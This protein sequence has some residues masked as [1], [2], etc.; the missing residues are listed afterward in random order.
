[1]CVATACF[2]PYAIHTNGGHDV[3]IDFEIPADAKAMRERVRQWVHDE[4]MPAEKGCW[5]ASDYKTILNELR[6]KARAQGLWCPFI[7]KEY[8]GMG[9]GPLANALVQM[10]LGESYLGALSMN[11]QGPDDATMLTLL[12]HGT[13]VSE[14]EVPEAAAER[15]EAHLL[16]DDREG[17][18]RRCHRHADARRGKGNDAYLLN[19]E[20]WFS[21]AASVADIALVMAKTD[22]ERAAP[23]AVFDL[24]RRAAE[25]RLQDQAR[26][27]D[28]GAR[29]PA[30]AHPGRRPCRSRDQ[31]PR[32]AGR[33]PAWR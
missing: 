9:L 22:P 16:F 17:G 15:R 11:T 32:S 10:E 14:G 21:S 26:H 18:R 31:G 24:P 13:D 20:K 19:G 5:R 2:A 6:A 27:P 25:P 4:C 8:G 29:G 28:D 12:E 7:P 33:K 3:A 1:M 23:Q 30:V